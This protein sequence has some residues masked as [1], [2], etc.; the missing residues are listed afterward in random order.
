MKIEE[1]RKLTPQQRFLYW[2]KERNQILL[3]RNAG[4]P[5]PWT[6]DE[7]LQNYRFCNVRRMNDKVSQW[8]L[9]KWYEPYY[10]HRNA[11]TACALAR[12]FN[13]PETLQA[14]GYPVEFDVDHI[15][16]VCA[17]LKKQG[18]TLFNPAYVISGGTGG[19]ERGIVSKDKV[20]I[21][22]DHVIGPLNKTPP[23]LP[24]TNM[25]AWVEALC[26]YNGFGSFMAGQVVADLR[27]AVEGAWVDKDSYAPQGPGSSRGL[28]RLLGLAPKKYAFSQDEFSEHLTQLIALVKKKL[29]IPNL[30]AID[31]QS[32]LCETDKYE[33]VLW[34]E[35]KPKQKYNGKSDQLTF[36]F[37]PNP[38]NLVPSLEKIISGAQTG[39]DLAGLDAAI[40]MGLETGGTMPKGYKNL[41]GNHPEFAELYSIKQ[42]TSEEYPPRTEQNVIDSDATL[43]LGTRFETA[44]E[45]CTLNML[46]KHKK[47]Y[48]RVHFRREEWVNP[49]AVRQWLIDTKVKVLNIAGNSEKSSP[50]IYQK[51][52]DF[53]L[54][55]IGGAS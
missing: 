24:Y 48:Y 4:K 47:P 39:A 17:S 10:D 1:V 14:I 13:K 29:N 2:V 5:K 42:H 55:V 25:Q 31:V 26:E 28:C 54:A 21:I 38:T 3:K 43:I 27:W 35:G 40:K 36:S 9:K 49:V 6:D 46:R 45:A 15:K 19:G 44:G 20:D 41:T 53:L 11:L 16:K 51:V 7:I 22:L 23:Q 18:K 33:R 37:S 34:G 8:L 30:E 50:G 12:H 52:Y 32:L